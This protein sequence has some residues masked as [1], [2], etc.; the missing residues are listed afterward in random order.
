MVHRKKKNNFPWR[1]HQFKRDHPFKVCQLRA[2][3]LRPFQHTVRRSRHAF[4]RWPWVPQQTVAASSR[5]TRTYL[6]DVFVL[7]SRDRLA[8]ECPG[9]SPPLPHKAN[10]SRRR[11]LFLSSRADDILFSC[12]PKGYYVNFFGFDLKRF[13]NKLLEQTH[14]ATKSDEFFRESLQRRE[15]YSISL[16]LS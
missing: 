10:S 11:F 2:Q 12:S 13:L 16:S 9:N 15:R 3:T 4:A 7:H 1:N 8:F 6:S 5:G 14:L